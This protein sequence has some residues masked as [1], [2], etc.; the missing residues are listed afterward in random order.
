M[1]KFFWLNAIV[2]AAL[3]C[4][5]FVGPTHQQTG[6]TLQ[7]LARTL[8][9]PQGYLAARPPAFFNRDNLFEAI[10]GM[11]PEYIGYGCKALAMLEWPPAQNKGEKVEAQLYD[12]G[13]PL[14]AFG[15]YSRAHVG[16]GEFADVGEEAAVAEDSVE[17]ARGPYYVRLT[18]PP[19]ARRL[20]EGL[21]KAIV[22]K[23]PPG[24]RPAQFIAA[25]PTEGR[26]ERSERWI[27]DSAFGMEFMRNV[28][29]ARYRVGGKEI[30]LYLAPLAG[31]PEAKSA[32]EQFRQTVKARSP[33]LTAEMQPGFTYS[34][35]YLGPVGVFQPG[36]RLVVVVGYEKNAAII[37][38]LQKLGGARGAASTSGK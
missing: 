22:A 35:Q 14:G 2:V 8:S 4:G 6:P 13:S 25:L 10:D 32:L 28:V 7:T 12:M 11:A 1:R 27:P 26:I 20:L 18:G 29:A 38:L 23:V 37:A 31:I 9:A 19:E 36:P 21:A 15:I 34:D 3:G 24:P 30:E 17:F 5:R 16:K 33:Q